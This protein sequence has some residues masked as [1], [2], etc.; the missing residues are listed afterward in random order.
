[1]NT[2]NSLFLLTEWNLGIS[3][4][5]IGYLTVLL[6][7]TVLFA[8]YMMIPNALNSFNKAQLKR[9]GRHECAGKESLDITGETTAAIAAALYEYFN[10]LH[11]VESGKITIKKVSKAYSPWN[12]KIYSVHRRV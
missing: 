8:I 12:S 9:Q 5:I 11:D 1:M 10:E 3:I 2:T 6:S 7:L 4:T